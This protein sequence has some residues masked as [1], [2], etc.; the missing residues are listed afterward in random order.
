MPARVVLGRVWRNDGRRDAAPGFL[1]TKGVGAC[2][3]AVVR[4]DEEVL[5]GFAAVG[6]DHESVEILGEDDAVAGVVGRE[7]DDVAVLA[8]GGAFDAGM[9]PEVER[10]VVCRCGVADCE[11]G[12]RRFGVWSGAEEEEAMG[13]S[14][15]LGVD[16]FGLLW[17]WFFGGVAEVLNDHVAVHTREAVVG[18]GVGRTDGDVF[19]DDGNVTLADFARDDGDVELYEFAVLAVDVELAGRSGSQRFALRLRHRM[20]FI[21]LVRLAV[22]ATYFDRSDANRGAYLALDLEV[23]FDVARRQAGV[24]EERGAQVDWDFFR[25]LCR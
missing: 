17:R 13:F 9:L 12:E 5:E 23:S 22:L 11:E 7:D 15:V 14:D 4:D 8:E 19:P 16:E 18:H 21:R 3:G 1:A 6:G 20:V 10:V 24:A 25:C 2:F